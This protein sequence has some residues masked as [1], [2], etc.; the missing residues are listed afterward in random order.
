ML[1]FFQRHPRTVGETYWEHF[2]VAASFGAAMILGG[3]ACLIHAV[4]P[5]W[6]EFTASRVILQLYTRMLTNR[7]RKPGAVDLDYAI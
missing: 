5:A 2:S 7:R 3:I 4:F 6:F 1:E